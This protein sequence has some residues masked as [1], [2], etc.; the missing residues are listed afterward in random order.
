MCERIVYPWDKH[1]NQECKI[2]VTSRVLLHLAEVGYVDA[3]V[4]TLTSAIIAQTTFGMV[5]V[6]CGYQWLICFEIML[7]YFRRTFFCLVCIYFYFLSSSFRIF[8]FSLLCF[9]YF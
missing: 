6:G 1:K 3:S 4:S 7:I 2:L 5:G 9:W 8:R